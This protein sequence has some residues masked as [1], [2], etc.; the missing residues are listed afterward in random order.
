MV[1]YSCTKPEMTGPHPLATPGRCLLGSLLNAIPFAVVSSVLAGWFMDRA[2]AVLAVRIGWPQIAFMSAYPDDVRNGYLLWALAVLVTVL[3]FSGLIG[4]LV[5]ASPGKAL[6]GIR[7]QREDGTPA[8]L[9]AMLRRALLINLLLLP[10]LLL[11]PVLGFVFGP[12]ADPFSA[13][14]LIFS[15][16][17]FAA[18]M[19][20]DASNA[21]ALQN[22][23]AMPTTTAAIAARA[24]RVRAL[25]ARS[26]V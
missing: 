16:L 10:L 15:I 2:E 13:V 12:A 9:G 25:F 14:A 11:G 8:G 1:E 7:Y 20:A 17:A 21:E 3:L 23:P 4:G 6:L 5:G 18:L 24:A 19:V 22:D 26:K